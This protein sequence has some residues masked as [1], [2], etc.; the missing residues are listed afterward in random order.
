[1]PRNLKLDTHSTD[2]V[3]RMAPSLTEVHNDLR[4]L[5]QVVLSTLC[6]QLPNLIRLIRPV[7]VVSSVNL[8]TDKST[9]I[10]T[11]GVKKGVQDTDLWH[12][13]VQGD[14]GGDVIYLSVQS[15]ISEE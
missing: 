4:F 10:R 12:T 1:M 5:G 8:N 7:T 14:G 3:V 15:S 9:V 11:W 13:G 2:V 6:G